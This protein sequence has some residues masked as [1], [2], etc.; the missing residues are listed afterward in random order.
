MLIRAPTTHLSAPVTMSGIEIRGQYLQCILL[1]AEWLVH[2]D[3]GRGTGSYLARSFVE[4]DGL[5]GLLIVIVNRLN[6]FGRAIQDREGVSSNIC[7]RNDVCSAVA[8]LK[9]TESLR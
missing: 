1:Q 5:K 2:A 7:L 9:M 6:D 3:F 8:S 4:R